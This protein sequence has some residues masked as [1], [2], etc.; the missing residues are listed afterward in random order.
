MVPTFDMNLENAPSGFA[1]FGHIIIL[2]AYFSIITIQ[3]TRKKDSMLCCRKPLKITIPHW[4]ICEGIAYSR[5]DRIGF[6]L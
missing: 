3:R 2:G 4:D 5:F 6:C 1:D